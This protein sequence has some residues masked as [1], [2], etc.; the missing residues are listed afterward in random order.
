MAF[1]FGSVGDLLN[2]GPMPQHTEKATDLSP[3][4]D[5]G[6]ASASHTNR[7]TDRAVLHTA[8]A[9]VLIALVLLWLMGGL[10]F[11]SATL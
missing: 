9:I 5:G 4:V 3:H 10:V 11:R 2:Y 7:A 8:V 6:P 1:E